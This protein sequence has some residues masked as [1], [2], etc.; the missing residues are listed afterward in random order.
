M[1][2]L[3]L[4]GE[5]ASYDDFVS[6]A[7]DEPWSDGLPCSPYEAHTVARAI[8]RLGAAGES[9]A[10]QCAPAVAL[11]DVCSLSLLAG[12]AEEHLPVVVAAVQALD[13]MVGRS[14]FDTVLDPEAQQAIIVNGP[15]RQALDV[16][17]GIGAF[18][19]GWRANATI[20]R[21][22]RFVVR[23]AGVRHAS[24][25]GDPAQYTFA[26]GEDE[27]G[28]NWIPLHVQRG[29]SADTSTASV[30]SFTKAGRNFDLA[31]V[32]LPEHIARMAVFLRDV[33]SG[34]D[35]F[36]DVPLTILLAVG[37]ERRRRYLDGGWSKRDVQCRLFEALISQDQFGRPLTLASPEDVVIVAVGGPADSSEWCFVGRAGSPGTQP[38]PNLEALP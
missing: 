30:H 10:L 3:E 13:A 15:I 20:G 1:T 38:I 22:V 28:S 9:F 35:W 29:F 7:A 31:N 4:L 5:A 27:E 33:A 19:P 8:D 25:F 17:C 21:A 6:R 32:T 11:S 2:S 14:G 12:C 37:H 23:Y 16:N 18:G 36:G 24:A 26:F 34:T